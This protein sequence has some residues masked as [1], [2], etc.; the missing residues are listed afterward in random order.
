MNSIRTD[1]NRVIVREKI[2]PSTIPPRD[3]TRSLLHSDITRRFVT[4]GT[5]VLLFAGR[6]YATT[7]VLIGTS[8]EFVMS[9]FARFRRTRKRLC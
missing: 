8:M 4:F 6:G 9:P 3:R 7:F 1:L 5:L 2:H